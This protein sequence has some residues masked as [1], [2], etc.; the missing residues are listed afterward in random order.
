MKWL[1]GI[2][3]LLDMSLSKVWEF[4]IVGAVLLQPLL[5]LLR[6]QAFGGH[7]QFVQDL[8]SRAGIGLVHASIFLPDTCRDLAVWEIKKITKSRHDKFII[9]F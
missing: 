7:A 1:D 6:R 8:F 3:D 4:V 9:C 5:R 2:T